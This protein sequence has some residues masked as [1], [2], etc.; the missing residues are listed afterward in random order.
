MMKETIYQKV[1]DEKKAELNDLKEEIKA[2]EDLE[3]Y[4]LM[5]DLGLYETIPLY[6]EELFDYRNSFTGND[7][8]R[9]KLVPLDITDEEL[10]RV[11]ALDDE[12]KALKQKRGLKNDTIFTRFIRVSSLV[13]LLLSILFCVALLAFNSYI[14]AGVVF[15]VTVPL[16]L[17][18]LLESERFRLQN[19]K[20][21]D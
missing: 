2:S 19:K 12:I 16:N 11:K 9:Y 10:L 1:L 13:G 6:N 17:M 18:L 4:H 21:S 20:K 15:L 3:R 7:G 14:E 5:L 8:Q